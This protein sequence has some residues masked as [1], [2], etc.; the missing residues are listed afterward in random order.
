[1]K[2]VC[3]LGNPGPE[4]ER[5]RHNLG[6]TVV[7]RLARR[8]DAG[9]AGRAVWF[10]YRPALYAGRTVYLV[11]P[12]TYVNRSGLAVREA[13]E[14]FAAE[15]TELCVISDDFELPLGTVRIR[16]AG[17]SGG[18]RGLASII[19]TLGRDDF[20]RV[21]CGIGPLPDEVAS[22][23]D[24]IP[25]FVLSPFRPEEQEVVRQMI[26]RVV[27]AL[28]LIVHGDLDLAISRYSGPN[29]TPGQ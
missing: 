23:R 28:V 4:Y 2:M 29:P 9:V 17:S 26:S 14:R 22:H 16:T 13:L 27:E 6:F 20:V 1:M 10:A 18:H 12:H 15:P 5:T 3:G 19:E 25:N 8:L 24:E 21:R 11:R 7:D